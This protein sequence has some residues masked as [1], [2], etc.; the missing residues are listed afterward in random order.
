[1]ERQVERERV[2]PRPSGPVVFP[3]GLASQVE[4]P[5]GRP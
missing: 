1:M 3:L 2:G 5:L 4:R